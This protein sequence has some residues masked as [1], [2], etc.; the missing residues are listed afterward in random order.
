MNV[1]NHPSFAGIEDPNLRTLIT[2]II[3]E[4]YKYIAQDERERIRD[5]QRQGIEIVKRQRK[6]KGHQREYSSTSPNR[7][8]RYVYNEAVRLLA[9]REAAIK[10]DPEHAMTKRQ[11]ARSLGIANATLWRIEQYSREDQ[12]NS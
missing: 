7:T 2:N 9:A 5:R 8:K 10:T 3:V 4:L 12:R 1:L 11:I 6:Y